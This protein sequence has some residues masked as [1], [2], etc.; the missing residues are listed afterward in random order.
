MFG[1]DHFFLK[2]DGVTNPSI[3]DLK[4]A[5]SSAEHPKW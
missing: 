3:I 1:K 5:D 2:D 4:D